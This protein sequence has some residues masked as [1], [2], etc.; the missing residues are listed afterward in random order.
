VGVPEEVLLEEAH[1]GTGSVRQTKAD[2]VIQS[3]EGPVADHI[4]VVAA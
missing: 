4:I 2:E 3:M 1:A